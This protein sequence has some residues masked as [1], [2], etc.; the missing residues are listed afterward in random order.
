MKTGGTNALALVDI[1][2]V[3]LLRLGIEESLAVRCDW[4]AQLLCLRPPSLS[5]FLLQLSAAVRASR[6]PPNRLT[7]S[8]ELSVSKASFR[9]RGIDEATAI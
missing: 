4:R 6:P 5:V 3:P 7:R 1:S 9:I 2:L 8:S